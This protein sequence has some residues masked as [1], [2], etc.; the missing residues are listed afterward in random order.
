MNDLCQQQFVGVIEN[1][2]LNTTKLDTSCASAAIAGLR[3]CRP[4]TRSPFVSRMNVGDPFETIWGSRELKSN[5]DKAIRCCL[6][7][8]NAQRRGLHL[9]WGSLVRS[10][11]PS[12]RVVM[13]ALILSSLIC[14]AWLDS[15]LRHVGLNPCHEI[16]SPPSSNCLH[17][18]GHGSFRI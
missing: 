7:N 6:L 2:L 12:D 3:L 18:T 13:R 1:P 8:T 14:I 17:S 11:T 9:R 16:P 10:V 15:R 4:F 5:D